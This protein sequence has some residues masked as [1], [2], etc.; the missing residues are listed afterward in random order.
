MNIEGEFDHYPIDWQIAT[1]D[2][3]EKVNEVKILPRGMR[4]QG[5]KDEQVYELTYGQ[6]N[7]TVTFN[8]RTGEA[9][10]YVENILDPDK[11]QPDETTV[12]YL[13]AKQM[14][15]GFATADGRPV[16]YGLRTENE[17]MRDWARTKGKGIFNWREEGN[18]EEP[19]GG[20]LFVFETEIPPKTLQ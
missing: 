5:N 14:M 3:L 11:R 10:T 19:D 8:H 13:A 7:L 12:L 17:N 2:L 16:K 18:Y 20:N 4:E 1:Q 9:G 15:E 6:K